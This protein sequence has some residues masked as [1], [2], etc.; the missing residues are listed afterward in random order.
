VWGNEERVRKQHMMKRYEYEQAVEPGINYTEDTSRTQP[1]LAMRDCSLWQAGVDEP[2]SG[3]N[4]LA[5]RQ[6]FG[7]VSVP[8]EGI[9]GVETKPEFRRQGYVGKLL[10]KVIESAA[11]RVPVLF[12]SE[13]IEDLYEKFGFVNCLADACVS[14]PVRNVERMIG[15]A[16][17]A[18]GNLRSFSHADLPAMIALYNTAHAQRP[19]TRERPAEWNGLLA[20]RTWQPGSEVIILERD[21]Q[22][23][24]YAILREPQYGH[25][26]DSL[27]ADELAASDIEAAQALLAEVATRCLQIRLSEFSV[28][29][30]L[31]S[32]VG[33]AAQRIGCTYRQTFARS[34]GMMGA[35]LDRQR[36][37]ALLEPELRRRLPSA[38]LQAVHTA[39]FDALCRGQ[40]VPDARD[41]LRLLVG[42]WS[43]ANARAY[44]M[45][46]PAEYER[47]LGAWFPGG[48]TQVLALPYAHTLDRY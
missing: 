1:G 34:G 45:A 9:G 4:L 5:F 28:R 18:P 13:A 2:I 30:P 24:G 16:A 7:A 38:D 23:A 39:A 22:V 25:V 40:L 27:D 10:T 14:L 12:V 26:M 32:A 19:W 11:K 46:V 6:R 41:L 36:L 3:L 8:A 33:Q 43:T 44:G 17:Q 47:I 37:L 15:L 20:T 48:G 35:I 29:E 31:D 21:G 42:H